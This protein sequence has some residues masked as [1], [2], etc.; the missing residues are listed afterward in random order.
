[1]SSY[2]L[3][4]LTDDIPQQVRIAVPRGSHHPSISYPPT[5]T[6]RDDTGLQPSPGGR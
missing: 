6:R 4:E 5:G 1:M 3:H 2:G